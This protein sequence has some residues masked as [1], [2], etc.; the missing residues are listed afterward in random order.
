MQKLA[1]KSFGK[2]FRRQLVSLAESFTAARMKV[3][4]SAAAGDEEGG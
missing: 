2:G 3:F 1:K 4:G